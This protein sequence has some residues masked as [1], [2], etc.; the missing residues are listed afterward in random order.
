M[1]N[2]NPKVSI[3]TVCYNAEDFIEETILSVLDQ[4]YFNIEY[5]IIDG[6]STDNTLKIID[7]YIK[8]IS[9]LVSEKDNGV[10]DAMNKGIKISTGDWVIFMNAGD[11]FYSENTVTLLNLNNKEE[12]AL[13]YGNTITSNITRSPFSQK[14]L[15]FGMIYA[16]HQS[17][18]YNKRLLEGTL[19][20]D[21]KFHLFGE[22][23]LASRIYNKKLKTEY[24]N[25]TISNYLGGGI[26]SEIS[27]R[28]RIAKY[29]Y[30]FKNFGLEGIF[31]SILYRLGIAQLPREIK[32]DF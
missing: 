17:T 25:L 27:Q 18:V 30:V 6:K 2:E 20:Y 15:Y 14:S 19:F 16:C 10:F 28:A 23:D 26:S 5:I 1:K 32:N 8:D 31:K 7:K 11:T 22:F 13:V 4:T 9:I 12:I 24:L 3:V 21:T 29:Y